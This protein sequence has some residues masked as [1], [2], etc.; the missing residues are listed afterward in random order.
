[1]RPPGRAWSISIGKARRRPSSSLLTI[2][3]SVVGGVFWRVAAAMHE[4]GALEAHHHGAVLVEP[5]RRHRDDPLGRSAFRLALGEH[6]AL[7]IERVAGEDG[8]G[9]L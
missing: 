7:G 4:H 1:M 3:S 2:K 5:A 9:R 8:M 6:G